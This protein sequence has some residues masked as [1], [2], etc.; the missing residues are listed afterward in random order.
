M[1]IID[2]PKPGLRNIKTALSVF[3]CVLLFELIGRPN[4]LFACSA[5]IICM[6]ETVF[7]SYKSGVDRL[8]GTLIGGVVGLVFL[9]IKNYLSLFPTQSVI[10]GIGIVIVIYL[11]TLLQKS[12]TTVISC[13]VFL[14]IVISVSEISPYLYAANRMLDTFVGIIV[15]LIVNRSIYPLGE[16]ESPP[17]VD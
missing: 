6:K 3:L 16:T 5:A 12:D 4:P 10:V 2:I 15:A 7:N 17:D 14:A 9:L 11:C 1:K 8:V 13:I